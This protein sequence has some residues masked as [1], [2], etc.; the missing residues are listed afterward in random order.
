MGAEFH[1][2]LDLIEI[3][4]AEFY[5]KSRDRS[6]ENVFELVYQI[7]EL[8][9]GHNAPYWL[10]TTQHPYQFVPQTSKEQ[11]EATQQAIEAL[12][13]GGM[14]S[15]AAHLRQAVD[16]INAHQY[17]DAITDCIHAVESVARKID[18]KSSAT[19]GPAL[20]SL[21]QA[22]LLNH[23][24]LKQAFLKLYGYTSNEQGLRHALLDQ[25]AANVGLEEAVFMFGA[26]ASFAAYLTQ[27]HRQAGGA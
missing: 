22:G 4:I 3:T 20:H 6:R 10:D 17:A 12:H 1:Y 8:F 9:A 5:L 15:A 27:K 13:K 26:C 2:V 19:L 18:P 11:G 7:K 16:H 24:A 14:D 25:D 21:E 23:P